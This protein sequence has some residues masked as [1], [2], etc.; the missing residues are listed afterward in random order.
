MSLYT[1]PSIALFTCTIDFN[2]HTDLIILIWVLKSHRRNSIMKEAFVCFA[3]PPKLNSLVTF[4]VTALIRP[5][6]QFLSG[7]I[8]W[9]SKEEN[10]WHTKIQT[11]QTESQGKRLMW[12]NTFINWL[13][14]CWI[15][16]SSLSHLFLFLFT[17]WNKSNWMLTW[18]LKYGSVT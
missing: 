14:G 1:A 12:R 2:F 6:V 17:T 16:A 13:L 18:C 9:S 3:K 11:F 4:Y 7:P 5:E 10:T 8:S 15:P